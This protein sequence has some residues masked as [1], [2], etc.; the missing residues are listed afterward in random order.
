[1][2]RSSCRTHTVV[3]S[4]HCEPLCL[5]KQLRSE[6][7]A[8]ASIQAMHEENLQTQ[9]KIAKETVITTSTGAM[10]LSLNA[11]QSLDLTYDAV[12]AAHQK[13]EDIKKQAGVWRRKAEQAEE[14]AATMMAQVESYR[15][16]ALLAEEAVTHLLQQ[17][18]TQ[19]IPSSL[20]IINTG[21]LSASDVSAVLP[22]L[23]GLGMF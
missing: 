18:S 23:R 17:L 3:L 15:T 22:M 16:R 7:E 8:A 6:L 14:A 13:I 1:M 5:Q 20:D 21:C 2:H 19:G 9:K 12:A 11:M 10:L 4:N